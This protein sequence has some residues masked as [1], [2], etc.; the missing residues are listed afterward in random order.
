M[1][2]TPSKPSSGPDHRK[3]AGKQWEM[4]AYVAISLHH[5]RSKLYAAPI[6]SVRIGCL[7]YL[8]GNDSHLL[9]GVDYPL[10]VFS[11]AS[12]QVSKRLVLVPWDDIWVLIK[13]ILNQVQENVFDRP[14]HDT[15]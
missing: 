8:N 2:Y 10:F 1:H 12:H 5:F 6:L 7:I 4:A 14:S 9:Y 3:Y 11:V 13:A 15:S